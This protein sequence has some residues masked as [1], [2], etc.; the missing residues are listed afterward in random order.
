MKKNQEPRQA[1]ALIRRKRNIEEYQQSIKAKQS[2]PEDFEGS[3][4]EYMTF[5]AQKLKTA[6]SEVK[7]LEERLDPSIV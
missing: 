2:K 7:T 6:E 4:K 5:L 3:Q 1:T